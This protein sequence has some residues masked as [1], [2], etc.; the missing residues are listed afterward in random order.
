MQDLE[1][2]GQFHRQVKMFTA[3]DGIVTGI[4]I[5]MCRGDIAASRIIKNFCKTAVAANLVLLIRFRNLRVL[6]YESHAVPI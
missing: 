6:G 4:Q 2:L 1:K 3:S 5:K